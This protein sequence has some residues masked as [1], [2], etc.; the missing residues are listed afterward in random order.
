[1]KILRAA[2]LVPLLAAAA[3]VRKP[4][5]EPQP[6]ALKTVRSVPL[7]GA[8]LTL[9][10]WPAGAGWA[11]M[12]GAPAHI[13]YLDADGAV[14][15]ERD[16]SVMPTREILAGAGG[17]YQVA[18]GGV[19]EIGLT[20]DRLL[21]VSSRVKAM[22]LGP[23]A[24]P[25]I[26]TPEGARSLLDN[27]AQW[28]PAQALGGSGEDLWLLNDDAFIRARDG[29]RASPPPPGDF[30]GA[31]PDGFVSLDKDRLR[32]W[33]GRRGGGIRWKRKVT[34]PPQQAFGLG[35]SVWVFNEDGLIRGYSGHSG[36]QFALID[37]GQRGRLFTAPWRDGLLL[38]VQEGR[39]LFWLRSGSA[40]VVLMDFRPEGRI[41]GVAT[42]GDRVALLT[43]HQGKGESFSL[44]IFQPAVN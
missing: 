38:A 30:R 3:C 14:Q 35:T 31:T 33:S 17:L 13:R 10:P 36:F 2:A 4:A 22:T 8:G 24:Q 7:E 15:S 27:S 39:R 26:V 28:R 41:Y 37:A 34:V 32:Y 12:A 25:W 1:M 11:V 16:S 43:L 40:P 6:P 19:L 42:A 44:E 20:A 23:G 21:P 29:L 5:P 9:L 18:E